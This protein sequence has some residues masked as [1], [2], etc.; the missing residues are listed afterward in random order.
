MEYIFEKG[1]K[2]DDDVIK[3]YADKYN[4]RLITCDWAYRM[5]K[6][7]H[8]LLFWQKIFKAAKKQGIKIRSGWTHDERY[9]SW[10]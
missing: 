8:D 6:K 9:I 2:D 7:R 1:K 10:E 3:K 5:I 4:N